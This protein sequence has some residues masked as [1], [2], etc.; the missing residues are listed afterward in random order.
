MFK[1]LLGALACCGALVT[2]SGPAQAGT[3]M[4]AEFGGQP[5]IYQDGGRVTGCGVRIFGLTKYTSPREVVRV[6]DSSMV[7]YVEGM[8]LLKAGMGT[9][10][11]DAITEQKLRL[12]PVNISNFWMRRAGD[13]PPA[14]LNG[15]VLRSPEQPNFLL[16]GISMASFA[17][18]SEVVY[19]EVELQIGVRPDKIGID[20]VLSGK[21]VMSEEDIRRFGDCFDT[22]IKSMGEQKEKR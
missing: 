16:Y 12:K 20:W 9:T 13:N 15:K 17:D 2:L 14:P 1:K 6:I 21:V 19:G 3:I 7:F 22:I 5:L 8:S 18:L 10:T 11:G 4:A